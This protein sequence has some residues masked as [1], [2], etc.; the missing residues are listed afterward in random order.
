[1][2]WRDGAP[3]SRMNGNGYFVVR[4]A[5]RG[6]L[7][8]V[9]SSIAF[10]LMG[11]A[12]KVVSAM[13]ATELVVFFRNFFGLLVLLPW[14]LRRGGAGLRTDQPR[15]HLL[16]TLAGLAGM[17]CFFNAIA[18]LPLAE[19]VLFNYSA[20]LFIPLI[21]LIWLREPFPPLLQGAVLTGFAGVALILRPE[22]GG[23]GLGTAF[24]IAAALYTAVAMV[25][26]RKLTATEPPARIVFLFAAG[27]TV[28][29]ALPLPWVWATL[30]PGQWLQLFAVGALASAGQIL[31]TRAY[32]LAPAGQIGPYGYTTVVFAAACGWLFWGEVPDAQVG[33]GA[34]LVAT[35]GV[36]AL[37]VER[38]RGGAYNAG[39]RDARN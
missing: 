2:P 1:M 17:Y 10:A 12:I 26:I 31:M 15:L 4:P 38:P 22:S 14:L 33:A 37:R 28:I 23:L 6:A 35:A 24:G 9:S 25:T 13:V 5:V 11:A 36:L 34:L 18:L 27:A 21:A 39:A 30:T 29:S 7:L 20:P 19:A 3:P 16:R 8:M 32:A